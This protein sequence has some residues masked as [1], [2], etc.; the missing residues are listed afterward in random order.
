MVIRERMKHTFFAL[1]LVVVFGTQLP[2]TNANEIA[3]VHEIEFSETLKKLNAHHSDVLRQLEAANPPYQDPKKFDSE[4]FHYLA[5]KLLVIELRIYKHFHEHQDLF[6]KLVVDSGALA[7]A[8][9]AVQPTLQSALAFFNTAKRKMN[10]L[11]IDL[12]AATKENLQ[13]HEDATK[14]SEAM[15]TMRARIRLMAFATALSA[16]FG[17]IDL[18]SLPPSLSPITVLSVAL[19]TGYI[20]RQKRNTP[21]LKNAEDAATQK[22]NESTAHLKML[23][24]ERDLI[25]SQQAS[26]EQ[27]IRE[28]LQE[29]GQEPLGKNEDAALWLQKVAAEFNALDQEEACIAALKQ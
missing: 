7:N 21:A 2:L 16:T 5:A 20:L 9:K 17:I 27:E 29:W 19:G 10:S 4:T 8:R 23:T 11:E 13:L 28:L 24:T 3:S 6:Q 25:E 22:Y 26:Y 12:H 15:K 18:A 1:L 14:H